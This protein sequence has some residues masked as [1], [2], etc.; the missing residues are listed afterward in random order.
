MPYFWHNNNPCFMY[1]A[2]L[3]YTTNLYYK[4]KIEIKE[5]HHLGYKVLNGI[6]NCFILKIFLYII[7]P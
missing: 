2:I 6:K 3:I 4:H 5:A 7:K 1:I